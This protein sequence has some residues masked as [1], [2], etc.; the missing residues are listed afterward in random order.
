M[1]SDVMLQQTRRKQGETTLSSPP[2]ENLRNTIT[3]TGI[4]ARELVESMS[5]VVWSLDPRNDTVGQLAD[6]L[7]VFA[8]DLADGAD[9]QLDF[10]VSDTARQLRLH[11]EISRALLLVI[12]EALNNVIRHAA[13]SRIHVRIDAG[14]SSLRF[15]IK[16]DG[17]G[18]D[19][20]ALQRRSGLSHMEQRLQSC[21][22]TLRITSAPG[23]GTRIEGCIPHGRKN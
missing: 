2:S 17:A 23:S 22:G 6:R 8:N 5:D 7:R 4:I 20:A 1:L 13:A 16:D 15:V 10:M 18:F 11:A 12:K 19:P 9:I 21:G 3:R 14:A